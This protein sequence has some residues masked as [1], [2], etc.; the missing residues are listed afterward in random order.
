MS[1][2]KSY[3]DIYRDIEHLQ[4]WRNMPALPGSVEA[5]NQLVGKGNLQSLK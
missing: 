5:I 2:H 4:M 1:K 3:D